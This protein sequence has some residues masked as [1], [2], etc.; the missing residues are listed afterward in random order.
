MTLE[1]SVVLL[2]IFSMKVSFLELKN[3][4]L[5]ESCLESKTTICVRS[6]KA[7]LLVYVCQDPVK[8]TETTGLER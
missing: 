4:L 2:L 3:S 6:E 1:L 5:E 8:N 7:R